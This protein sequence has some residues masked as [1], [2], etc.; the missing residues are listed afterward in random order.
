MQ[1]LYRQEHRLPHAGRLLLA[2]VLSPFRI[3]SPATNTVK[4]TPTYEQTIR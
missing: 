4:A 1:D 2:L 3:R